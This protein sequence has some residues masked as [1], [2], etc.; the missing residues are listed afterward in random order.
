[1][2]K[3]VSILFPA[4]QLKAL[5]SQLG[6]MRPVC[7]LLAG[8]AVLAA[9]G[10]SPP[11]RSPEMQLAP[12]Q[13]D[14]S[15]PAAAVEAID[16]L[17]REI[18]SFN[19]RFGPAFWL[20]DTFP[21]QD[22]QAV[23]AAAENL[24]RQIHMGALERI[25]RKFGATA[26]G[27][28]ASRKLMHLAH[29]TPFPMPGDAEARAGLTAQVEALGRSY[30]GIEVC[31]ENACFGASEADRRLR[32]TGDAAARSAIWSAWRKAAAPLK[33]QFVKLT[34]A[35][36]AAAR[37][38]GYADMAV[39]WMAR[40][41]R[42]TTAWIQ[43][44]DAL[45]ADLAPFASAL[46]CHVKAELKEDM[47]E[48][49]NIQ[50]AALGS[51]SGRDWR[52]LHERVRAG[53]PSHK[54]PAL[55]LA[56]KFATVEDMMRWAEST[57]RS[58]GFPPL[59]DSFWVRSQFVRPKRKIS[60][61]PRFG[62]NVD[63]HRDVRLTMCGEL[64]RKDFIW[65]HGM[66]AFLY[67]DL[68]FADQDWV[69]RDPPHLGFHFANSDAMELALTPEFLHREGLLD[70]LPSEDE[71]LSRM[72]HDALRIL[73]GIGYAFAVD[74]WRWEAF[75]GG[76]E[77]SALEDR[78]WTLRAAYQGVAR[79]QAPSAGF[80]P[81]AHEAIARNQELLPGAL[82]QVLQFQFYAE[83]CKAAGHR[84][85]LHSCSFY[86]SKAVGKRIW[87]ILAMGASKPWYAVLEAYT[88]S[89]RMNAG[90]LLDYFTPLRHWLDGKN[91]D[92]TC[93]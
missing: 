68:A 49:T 66:L 86:G 70:A 38:W 27:G 20:A 47:P 78:W 46:R 79:P 31:I 32:E 56:G 30:A 5:A 93:R 62:T 42:S 11:E 59:P 65:G 13:G 34:A 76:L 75:S 50:A 23:A 43:E 80:E 69:F 18:D 12:A 1:M 60:A 77:G 3:A 72:L 73:P 9:A 48:G 7:G 92:R 19:R 29:R 35:L 71:R 91:A 81:L 8:L 82:G 24:L 2:D 63:W 33:P 17:D 21:S 4:G 58:A 39:W 85:P 26:H 51:L 40:Y 53:L 87:P 89:P 36:N 15:G 64:T 37:N 6:W 16:A 55:R 74:R 45:W 83:A 28:P 54:D 25:E 22:A 14:K 88:G 10:C 67:Y 61:C 90:P 57:Y 52:H 41:E 44:L 84:G